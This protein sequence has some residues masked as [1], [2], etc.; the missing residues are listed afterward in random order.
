MWVLLALVVAL[1]GGFVMY[2]SSRPGRWYDIGAM[3]FA[4]GLLAFLL[5]VGLHQLGGG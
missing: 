2:V 1:I 4:C 3:C 5:R